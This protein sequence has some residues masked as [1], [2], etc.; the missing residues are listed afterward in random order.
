MPFVSRNP[1]TG[2]LKWLFIVAIVALIAGLFYKQR[3]RVLICAAKAGVIIGTG[4]GVICRN[5]KHAIQRPRPFSALPDV[6]R[7]GQS[8]KAASTSPVAETKGIVPPHPPMTSTNSMPSAHAANWFA[9]TM[10]A[11]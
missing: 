4:D 5:L 9:G 7:P 1:F 3:H 11:L 10:V 2:P 6:K 8:T